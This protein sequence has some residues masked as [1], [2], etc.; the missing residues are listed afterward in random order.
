MKS[1]KRLQ[2]IKDVFKDDP[3]YRH[4]S[5][6]VKWLIKRINKLTKALQTISG[7]CHHGF[8]EVGTCDPVCDQCIAKKV[9]ES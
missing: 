6:D 4:Y 7:K 8:D 2:Y 1:D 5:D 3:Y 9:L